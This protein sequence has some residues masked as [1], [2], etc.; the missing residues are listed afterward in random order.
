MRRSAIFRPAALVATSI[1]LAA[2]SGCGSAADESS[3]QKH[4]RQSTATSASVP[5]QFEMD[6]DYPTFAG[7]GALTAS[8]S[9]VVLGHV[10]SVGPGPP[11]SLGTDEQGG[12]I[13]ALPQTESTVQVASVLHGN[14]A[15][16]STIIVVRPGGI[17]EAGQVADPE[18]SQLVVGDKAIFFVRWGGDGKYYPLAGGFAVALFEGEGK[19]VLPGEALA[20]GAPVTFNAQEVVP[21]IDRVRFIGLDPPARVVQGNLQ[22]G[23]VE[24]VRSSSGDFTIEGSGL[25]AGSALE[26]SVVVSRRRA[27]GQVTV[28]GKAYTLE[29]ASVTVDQGQK[30]QLVGPAKSG[31]TTRTLTVEVVDS[32]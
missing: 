27:S 21:A 24:I 16:A 20:D 9:H 22:S 2:L 6:M 12:T 19:Y 32:Q 3:T 10:V 4:G 14:L 1:I 30:V 26:L 11:L 25:V 17:T 7:V 28:D 23:D 29:G 18:M 8:A 15:G 5:T 13:P 31:S